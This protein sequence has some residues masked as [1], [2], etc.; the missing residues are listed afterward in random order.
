VIGLIALIVYGPVVK[1]FTATVS[2]SLGTPP[3]TR[4]PGRGRTASAAT[5]ADPQACSGR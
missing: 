2:G 3:A 5:R 1:A 4:R